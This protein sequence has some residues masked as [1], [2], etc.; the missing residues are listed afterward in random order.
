[1]LHIK[2]LF[3]QFRHPLPYSRFILQRLPVFPTIYFDS[4]RYIQMWNIRI[5]QR[6]IYMPKK[7]DKRGYTETRILLK[8]LTNDEPTTTYELTRVLYATTGKTEDFKGDYLKRSYPHVHR[9]VSKLKEEGLVSSE[10]VKDPG[11]PYKDNL[12]LTLTGFCQIFIPLRFIRLWLYDETNSNKILTVKKKIADTSQILEFFPELI[13]ECLGSDIVTDEKKFYQLLLEIIHRFKDLH[14]ILKEISNIFDKYPDLKS[15][16]ALD[17]ILNAIY[18]AAEGVEV[19]DSRYIKSPEEAFER[20]FFRHFVRPYERGRPSMDM[21][22]GLPYAFS[23]SVDILCKSPK[24]Q[25]EFI[26]YINIEQNILKHSIKI[27][28]DMFSRIF[29]SEKEEHTT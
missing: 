16:S 10:T 4:K 23:Q 2:N 17:N 21:N 1:M 24:I 9:I 25:V 11:G 26:A 13:R 18:S 3:F 5:P 15:D 7:I 19:R 8:I 29:D 6:V 20:Y 14:W 12:H 22:T 27:L 28:D